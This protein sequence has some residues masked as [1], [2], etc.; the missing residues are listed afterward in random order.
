VQAIGLAGNQIDS[1]VI[2]RQVADRQVEDG[3]KT[4]R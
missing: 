2:D 3:Q 1:K 4:G